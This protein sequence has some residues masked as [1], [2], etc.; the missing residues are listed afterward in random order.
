M[1][2]GP[3]DVA[4]ACLAPLCAVAQI[5]VARMALIALTS[6]NVAFAAAVSRYFVTSKVANGSQ[7]ITIAS[8][9]SV[10]IFQL[11]IPEM[12]HADITS[13]SF[14][15]PFADTSSGNKTMHG[16]RT[17]ITLA[18][19]LGT[20]RIAITLS[21]YVR[22]G[23]VSAWLLIKERFAFLTVMAH[24]VVSAFIADTAADT[25][26]C[27][28]NGGIEVT[29]GGV[30]VAIAPFACICILSL[31]RSPRQIIVKVFTL[32]AVQSLRVV[33]TFASTMYHVSVVLLPWKWNTPGG[34]AVAGTA[35]TD[36]HVVQGIVI[37]LFD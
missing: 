24:G 8:F 14:N 6:S 35:A 30:V 12:I 17:T 13:A 16:I 22:I 37:F 26:G 25:T 2:I 5:P 29:P 9:T 34:V 1:I 28:V 27:L 32:L 33:R 19:M 7:L 11:Q 31:C 4:V 23:D 10:R 20:N 3:A 36:H 18:S 15:I 21:A